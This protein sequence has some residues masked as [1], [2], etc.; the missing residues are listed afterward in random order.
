MGL[1]EYRSAIAVKFSRMH[2]D[3]TLSTKDKKPGIRGF[4][5]KFK[6]FVEQIQFNNSPKKQALFAKF[7]FKGI[8]AD[9][10]KKL[11]YLEE[12]YQAVGSEDFPFS[13]NKIVESYVRRLLL[14]TAVAH[15]DLLAGN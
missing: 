2:R 1:P 11:L 5:E 10:E 8:F 15:N 13:G 4:L 12:C 6:G 3:L 7:D 14:K 9:M